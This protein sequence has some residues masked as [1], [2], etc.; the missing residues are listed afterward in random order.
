MLHYA[1]RDGAVAEA[2]ELQRMKL[3]LQSVAGSR[4][5]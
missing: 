2:A 3:I 5:I 4:R 1:H